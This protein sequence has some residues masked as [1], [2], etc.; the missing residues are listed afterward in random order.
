MTPGQSKA[1]RSWLGWTFEAASAKAGIAKSTLQR[2][3]KGENVMH[4]TVLSLQRAYEAAGI[5]FQGRIGVI[6][7]KADDGEDRPQTKK[8]PQP[9]S[10]T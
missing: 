1:A 5:E 8:A 3:E 9:S 6:Y 10:H 4:R 2:F 7:H